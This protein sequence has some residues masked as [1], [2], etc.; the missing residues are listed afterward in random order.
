LLVN[1]QSI[2]DH[3]YDKFIVKNWSEHKDM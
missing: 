1:N 3:L 2:D